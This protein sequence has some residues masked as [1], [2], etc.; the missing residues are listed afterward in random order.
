ME[1]SESKIKG[2]ENQ[3]RKTGMPLEIRISSLL[4]QNWKRVQNQDTYFDDK[5]DTLREIDICASI[6]P[7]R[8]KNVELEAN[9]VIECKQS[10]KLDWVFFTR[11]FVFKPESIAGQYSD[12]VQM[13]ARN[14]AREEIM[15]LILENLPLHYKKAQDIAVTFK[16][17]SGGQNKN[18]IGTKIKQLEDVIFEAREQVKSYV[19]LTIDQDIDDRVATLPYTI[20]LYFPCIV[21]RGTEGAGLYQA[22]VVNDEIRIQETDHV[23]LSSL[24][25]SKYSTYEKNILIDVV[26]EDYFSKVHEKQIIQDIEN[27]E[28]AINAN[29]DKI[30]SRIEEI[31]GFLDSVGKERV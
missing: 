3:L 12:E 15:S 25:K 2:M 1:T 13:A 22:Q 18:E 31:L 14:R 4:D 8:I 27:I 24:Y 29:S 5:M 26:T 21:F 7:K 28:V 20:E 30:S 9:L 23:I 10:E 11:P 17:L 6:S 16:V 19:N